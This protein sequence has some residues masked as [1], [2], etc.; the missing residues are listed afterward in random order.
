MIKNPK[1]DNLWTFM[2]K[3]TKKTFP[4]LNSATNKQYKYINDAKLQ[5]Q[6]MHQTN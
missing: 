5:K 1:Y 2:V 3:P 4:F 6:T